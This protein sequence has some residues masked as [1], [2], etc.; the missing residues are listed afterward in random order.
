[1]QD[2]NLLQV[3]LNRTAIQAVTRRARPAG[4]KAIL[5]DP[6]NSGKSAFWRFFRFCAPMPDVRNESLPQVQLPALLFPTA[7]IMKPTA[8]SATVTRLLN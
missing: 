1:M 8:V 2:E 6:P 3:R 7:E 5:H 4:P